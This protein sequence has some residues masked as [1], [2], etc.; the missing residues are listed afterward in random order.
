MKQFQLFGTINN[1][2]DRDPPFTGGGLSG[3]SAQYHDTLGRSYRL[4]IRMRF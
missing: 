2:F 3:A 1:L 4:G